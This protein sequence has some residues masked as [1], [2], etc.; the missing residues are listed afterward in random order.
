M[1][2]I[3]RITYES[4]TLKL[5]LNFAVLAVYHVYFSKKAV[6]SEQSYVSVF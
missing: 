5:F 3:G 1:R 2:K 6:A 4:S